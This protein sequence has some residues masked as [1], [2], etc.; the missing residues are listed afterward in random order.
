MSPDEVEQA[1]VDADDGSPEEVGEMEEIS[2]ESPA[3]W[4]PETWA[5]GV[6]Y[7]LTHPEPEKDRLSPVIVSGFLT[8]ERIQKIA[9]LPF[10]PTVEK[11]T[12]APFGPKIAFDAPRIA[13]DVS[14]CRVDDTVS[15]KIRRSP[16]VKKETIWYD[17]GKKYTKRT[18]AKAIDYNEEYEE[19]IVESFELQMEGKDDSIEKM[20]LWKDIFSGVCAY[21]Q[22]LFVRVDH[23][24][25]RVSTRTKHAQLFVDKCQEVVVKRY[26]A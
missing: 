12:T 20:R 2:E 18:A 1:H 17:N 5:A 24:E 10:P 23:S 8:P 6:E 19:K 25:A 7:L 14:F 3:L 9:N 4:S 16:L 11:A 21:C 26:A 15:F 13:S 22:E